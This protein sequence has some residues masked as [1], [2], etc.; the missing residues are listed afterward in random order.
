MP[1]QPSQRRHEAPIR[2]VNPSGQVRWVARYTDRHG[3]LKSAG[4]FAL[5]REAQDAIDAAYE[6]QHTAPVRT[7]TL[8]SYV[9]LWPDV[10]PRSKRTNAENA[11][12]I[13]V[14]LGIEVEGV[15]LRDWTARDLRRRHTLAVQAA[16]L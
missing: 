3:K 10:H 8:G 1:H 4:T 7:D 6:R 11:W 5:R 2:R 14:V 9:A 15:E 16:L 12:R 13:G